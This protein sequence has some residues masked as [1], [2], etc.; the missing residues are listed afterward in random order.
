MRNIK[1]V[2]FS[3]IGLLVSHPVS[4][5]VY[6]ETVE[7]SLIYCPDKVEC[8]TGGIARDGDEVSDSFCHPDYDKRVYVDRMMHNGRNGNYKGVYNFQAAYAHYDL[9]H[10]PIVSEVLCRYKLADSWINVTYKAIANFDVFYNKSTKW[11]I[12]QSINY[13][14]NSTCQASMATDC[15]LTSKP[16]VVIDSRVSISQFFKLI[17]SANGIRINES[18]LTSHL[19][20]YL[21]I[22]YDEAYVACGGVTQC[23]I[24]ISYTETGKAQVYYAGNIVIDMSD[25][26][27]ILQVNTGG[28]NGATGPYSLKK[29]RCLLI[30]CLTLCI[31]RFHSLKTTKAS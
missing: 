16:E 25:N 2:V 27:K 11:N 21:S 12:A 24:E 1:Y 29:I 4:A 13:K 15:P 26:M 22:N 8:V 3:L 5:Y 10:H 6:H 19:N 17:V 18:V 23:K 28:V 9:S 14:Q 31:R 30:P 7:P 20:Q